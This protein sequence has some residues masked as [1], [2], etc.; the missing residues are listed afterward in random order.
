MFQKLVSRFVVATKE[1]LYGFAMGSK[2]FAFS[3]ERLPFGKYIKKYNFLYVFG[4]ISLQVTMQLATTY[5]K[6]MYKS[7]G[8]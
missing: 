1:E 5:V 8:L 4:D 3:I 7:F 2:K 6:T